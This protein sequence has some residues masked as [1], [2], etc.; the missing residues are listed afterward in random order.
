[1]KGNK[2][3]MGVKIKATVA[4]KLN[5]SPDST[6]FSYF[7]CPLLIERFFLQLVLISDTVRNKLFMKFFLLLY[8]TLH[9]N[10]HNKLNIL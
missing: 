3:V 1:M 5:D 9:V 7:L 6:F 2:F 8:F 4:L 10:V